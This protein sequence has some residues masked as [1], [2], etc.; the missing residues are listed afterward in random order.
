LGQWNED[1]KVV[2]ELL[3]HAN[4]RV[5]LEVYPQANSDA[6]RAALTPFSGIF[7]VAKKASWTNGTLSCPKLKKATPSLGG[8]F[9]AIGSSFDRNSFSALI[10]FSR[11]DVSPLESGGDDG[12]RT[13]DLC[14]ERA[15]I[16]TF[17]QIPKQNGT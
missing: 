16:K 9:L 4:S 6:K 3:R 17:P 12:A 14:R 1:V 10:I 5:T 15:A 13:R 8:L 11:F 2:Q 7:V